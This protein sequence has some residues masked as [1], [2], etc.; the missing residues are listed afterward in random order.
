M[1]N[2]RI[3]AQI[4]ETWMK[5]SPNLQHLGLR[6]LQDLIIQLLQ[7]SQQTYIVVDA[8]DE[9]DHPNEVANILIMIAKHCSILVTSRSECEDTSTILESYPQIHISSDDVQ[10][11][12]DHFVKSSLQK[13]RRISKRSTEIKQHISRA[14]VKAADGMFLWVTLMIEMLGNQMSDHEIALALMQLPIGLTATYFRI[15]TEIDRLPSRGWC[16]R[17]ITWLL[18]ARRPL[19]LSELAS[20]VA[21]H[22][23]NKSAGWDRTKVPNDP[24]DIIYDCK[25]L[26]SCISTP[27]GRIVQFTHTSV[28][29]FLL[30]NP[31]E[32]A[33]TIPKYH[34]FPLSK[35][36]TLMAKW[37]LGYLA[38]K[39]KTPAEVLESY[40][41]LFTYVKSHWGTHIEESHSPE[42]L[43]IF[44]QVT[45][46]MEVTEGYECLNAP[47]EKEKNG[48]G[49]DL[50]SY[51]VRLKLGLFPPVSNPAHRLI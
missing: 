5:K 27:H 18:C 29:D 28:R 1:Y 25:G 41:N 38:L 44:T 12:I 6:N 50:D 9:C 2:P 24:L 35:G 16:M 3:V 31:A 13:H 11:D 17:A 45:S 51:T 20:A 15:L 22:D 32:V 39:G 8:L 46:D 14:L 23:M 26:L 33:S 10:A 49:L 7:Q 48:G 37:C 40:L 19:Q 34:I 43:D 21:I 4:K 30:A 47:Q 42:V 36:H